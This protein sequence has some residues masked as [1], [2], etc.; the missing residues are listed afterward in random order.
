MGWSAAC[1]SDHQSDLS[2]V[3]DWILSLANDVFVP[4]AVQKPDGK[5]AQL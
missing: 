2:D 3:R 4:G 1:T 5:D